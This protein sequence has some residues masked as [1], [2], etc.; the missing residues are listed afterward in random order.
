MKRDLKKVLG[1]L[2]QHKDEKSLKI[3]KCGNSLEDLITNFCLFVE[4]Y[5]DLNN[6]ET[7]ASQILAGLDVTKNKITK[8]TEEVAVYLEKPKFYEIFGIY[9]L[10]LIQAS[11]DQGHNGF[12]I[13]TSKTNNFFFNNSIRLR[14]RP[15]RLLQITITGTLPNFDFIQ[16]SYCDVKVFGDAGRRFGY[17]SKHSRHF[18]NGNASRFCGDLAE[19]SEFTVVGSI[20]SGCGVRA[21][22]CIF[23]LADTDELGRMMMSVGEGCTLYLLKDDKEIPYNTFYGRTLKRK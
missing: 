18:V 1:D 12:E 2:E 14:G 23:R 11:Y 16:F 5:D 22:R 8:F 4:G 10:K 20:G 19:D 9:L 6:V 15:D 7:N 3:E 13:N 17:K 21:K